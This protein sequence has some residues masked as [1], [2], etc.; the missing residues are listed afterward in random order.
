MNELNNDTI[1]INPRRVYK[2]D[3]CNRIDE[4]KNIVKRDG[5]FYCPKCGG[6]IRDITETTTGHDFMEIVL[7]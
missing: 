1:K 3:N 4:R 7:L 5:K 6:K 2:C